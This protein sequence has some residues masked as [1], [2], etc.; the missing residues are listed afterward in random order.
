MENTITST[1]AKTR[2]RS[3]QVI[4]YERKKIMKSQ[5]AQTSKGPIEYTLLGNGPMVL[6]CH[7]TSSN[8]FSTELS[9]P[10]VEAGFSVLTPSRPGYGRTPL[11]VGAGAA[12]TA[13]ALIALLDTLQVQTCA[14]VAISGGG[15]TG[16]ALAALYPQRIQQLILAAA[17]SHPEERP[18]EPA[19]KNQSAFYGP[20]HNLTWGM[21][22]LMSRLS[23]RAM[24]RQTLAIFSTHDPEDGLNKLSPEDIAK[25][26]RF[27]QG[28]SS[29]QGALADNA[30]TVGVDLL[31][32]IRQPTLV[33]HSREDNSVPFGHA[34]WSLKHIPQ[35]ELCEAGITGHFF[36][37]D[38]DYPRICQRMVTF[39]HEELRGK[40]KP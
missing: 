14:V 37:V 9:T 34:E 3:T 15:P 35:A 12:Q 5:I 10:L 4:D 31:K 22:G 6:V 1:N 16:I 24:A 26:C 36:W 7:G 39:L 2:N 27:Y 20:M 38:P 40:V 13:Q 25:I 28:H 11:E 8:C 18:N 30:H 21:L 29:R 23:P 19:Y 17:I 32:S 33:I